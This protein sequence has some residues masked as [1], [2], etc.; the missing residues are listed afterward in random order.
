MGHVS[1]AEY[2]QLLES[3]FRL[4]CKIEKDANI[5]HIVMKFNPYGTAALPYLKVPNINQPILVELIKLFCSRMASTMINL[6]LIYLGETSGN[7]SHSE[8]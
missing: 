8:H 1:F 4:Q 5:D 6:S 7:K 2:R 3:S